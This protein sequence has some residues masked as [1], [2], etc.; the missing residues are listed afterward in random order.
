[1]LADQCGNHA[2]QEVAGKEGNGC[3]GVGVWVGSG[4]GRG[5]GEVGVRPCKYKRRCS[6]VKSVVSLHVK[7]VVPVNRMA[8]NEVRGERGERTGS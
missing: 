3:S 6:V 2:A 7:S 8:G 5:G 4:A 1:V